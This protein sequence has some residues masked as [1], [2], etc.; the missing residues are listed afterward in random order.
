MK[1]C[2]TLA[3]IVA[4]LAVLLSP[5]LGTVGPYAQAQAQAQAQAGSRLFPE[6]GHSVKGRFLEYWETHGGLPQ[7]GYPISEEMQEVSPRDS[8]T[9][10]VQ[11]FERGVFELHP[12]NQQ[13][14][15]VLLSLLGVFEYGKRYGSAGASGQKASTDNPLFFKE[16]G[17]TIGGK[18]RAYWEAHGGLAQQGYPISDEFQEMSA[19]NGKTY[20]VQYFQRAVFELHPENQPPNYVLL[21]QLGTFRFRSSY[22]SPEVAI[23]VL[24]EHSSRLRVVASD[25]YVVWEDGTG[26]LFG[27]DPSAGKQVPV[28]VG[29]PFVQ[30]SPDISGAIVVYESR[31]D[32]K[33][34]VP[35]D[36]VVKNLET[37]ATR[38][39]P[40]GSLAYVYPK[41]AGQR[42]AWSDGLK[43]VLVDVESGATKEIASFQGG[44]NSNV[45]QAEISDEYLVW[46]EVAYFNARYDPPR[47]S[48]IKAYNFQTGAVKTV[49]EF[50]APSTGPRPEYALDDHRLALNEPLHRG[51][52][53]VVDLDTGE[54][55][56][57]A[58]EDRPSPNFVAPVLKG[59]VLFWSAYDSNSQGYNVWGVNLKAG[60]KPV[61]LV[62]GQGDQLASGIVGERLVWLSRSM[63][64]AYAG[65]G[66]APLGSLFATAPDRLKDLGR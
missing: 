40:T 46:S 30:Q 64:P 28:S 26:D 17:H 53:R 45:Q 10:T 32:D 48:Y 20:T 8:K 44:S 58:W 61:P 41:I 59:D 11:Y 21:S 24:P 51:S 63:D 49:L 54:A 43:L 7:Q 39:I 4:S 18:F 52:Y 14:N 33:N 65:I 36:V 3:A 19:L 2:R 9:Y 37:G 60:G 38:K 15:D 56:P 57:I 34:A 31:N 16:S 66:L 62:S 27:Y 13:P 23:R 12:E 22:L 1:V 47:T 29:E 50:E 35:A 42:V 6:T 25:R 55:T 5:A